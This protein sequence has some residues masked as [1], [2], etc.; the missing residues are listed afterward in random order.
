M[1]AV[2]TAAFVVQ[3]CVQQPA[4][5]GI[6]AVDAAGGARTCVAGPA[7]P[8]DGKAILDQVQTSNEGGWCGI[9]ASRGGKA[10]DAYLLVTRP[11]H[12][13]VY[14]HHVGA[15][16]RIDYT[17]DHG[18]TGTDNFAVRLIPGDAVIEGAVT[19]TR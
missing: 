12:G 11:T 15:S 3:G 4:W 9:I 17:P 16:T 7:S 19:V 8:P 14:A 1:L 2:V 6:F 13:K 5:N 18:F 10:Y